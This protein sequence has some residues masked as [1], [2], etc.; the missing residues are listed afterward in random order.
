MFALI[1]EAGNQLDASSNSKGL[2]LYYEKTVCDDYFSDNSANAICKLMGY[3][4]AISWASGQFYEIQSDLEIGLDNVE[5]SSGSWDS[6]DSTTSHNC[7]HYE[8][9]HLTCLSEEHIGELIKV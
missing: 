3:P 9:V 5:C 4:G 1:D 7:G 8:D 2:L 6:C